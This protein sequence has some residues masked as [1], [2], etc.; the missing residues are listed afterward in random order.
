M[1]VVKANGYG[2]GATVCA[3]MLVRAGATWLGVT[4]TAEGVRVRACVGPETDI[5]VMSG[6]LPEDVPALVEHG[7]TPVVW[8]REQ[9]EWLG[10]A[11]LPV[12]VEVDT[13][14]SRQGVR[15]GQDLDAVLG[16]IVGS[17]G[18]RVGAVFTHFGSSEEPGEAMTFGQERR[19]EGAMAQVAALGLQPDWVHAGN[20]S[21]VDNP[22][23]DAGWLVRLA[24]TVGARAMVRTGIGLY[25]YCLESDGAVVASGLRPVMQWKA[26]VLSVR[27]LE[28]GDT[29]GYNAIYRAHEARTVALLPVGYANG[30]RRELSS[31]D[32]SGGWV[33]I[34]GRKAPIVGRVSMNLTVVDVSGIEGVKAGDEVVVLGD[35]ATAEDHARLAGTIAYEILCGVHAG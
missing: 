23:G 29:V 17:P 2:H 22:V 20:T 18:L 27:E 25:G 14:M 7:L 33:M 10:S 6:F 35:G 34:G 13:G 1:A 21:S 31:A 24:A 32:G 12:H 28:A 3:S 11:E 19:F 9:V 30:L 5:L 16:L 8:T 26:R 4:N 15:P